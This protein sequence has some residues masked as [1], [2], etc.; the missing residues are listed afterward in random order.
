[1]K[2]NP[3]KFGKMNWSVLNL[4]SQ[5]HDLSTD[6]IENGVYLMEAFL[7]SKQKF[8]HPF[9]T[10]DRF[11]EVILVDKVNNSVWKDTDGYFGEWIECNE[12]GFDGFVHEFGERFDCKGCQEIRE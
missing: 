12:C 8:S 10:T 4:L 9:I 2:I 6:N 5:L 1:M 11:D 3:E 7:N